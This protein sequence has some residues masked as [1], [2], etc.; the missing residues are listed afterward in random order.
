MIEGRKRRPPIRYH[1]S[2]VHL[3]K[4]SPVDRSVVNPDPASHPPHVQSM[5]GRGQLTDQ[6]TLRSYHFYY[7]YYY[8]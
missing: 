5:E 8:C 7:Y 1:P 2:R 3:V 4:P 6:E